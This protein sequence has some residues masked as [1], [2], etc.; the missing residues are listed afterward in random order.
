MASSFGA[1]SRH[2]RTGDQETYYRMDRREFLFHY[3]RDDSSRALIN[4]YFSHREHPKGVLQPTQ[5]DVGMLFGELIALAAITVICFP[6]IVVWWVKFSRKRLLRQLKDY[7]SGKPIPR[8]IAKKR[9]YI[10]AL[11]GKEIV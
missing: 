8:S 7:F 10:E 5:G 11:H 3:G 6:L 9:L 2:G 1:G 4:F